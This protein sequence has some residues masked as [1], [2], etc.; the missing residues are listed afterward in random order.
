MI[1]RRDGPPLKQRKVDINTVPKEELEL[2]E[3]FFED[4]P[5]VK[6]NDMIDIPLLI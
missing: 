5:Q 3:F 2:M 1:F 4:I 6:N